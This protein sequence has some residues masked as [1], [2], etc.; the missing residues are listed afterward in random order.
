MPENHHP[1]HDEKLLE[2]FRR[3]ALAQVVLSPLTYNSAHALRMRLYR[4]KRT[5]AQEAHADSASAQLTIIK[6]KQLG[7]D[8]W[9]II[10]QPSDWDY[11]Q[12][13]ATAGIS[14]ATAPANDPPDLD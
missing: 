9:A 11:E 6:L 5:L 10:V 2:T 13:F 8:Q 12:A 3:G 4:L 7:N 14:T 1:M